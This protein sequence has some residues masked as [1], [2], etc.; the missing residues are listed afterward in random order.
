MAGDDPS[1]AVK[2]PAS[3][4]HNID[5]LLQKEAS[6]VNLVQ[7]EA[8]TIK[9]VT[10]SL[11]DLTELSVEELDERENEAVNTIKRTF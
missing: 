8:A 7:N 10:E 1:P 9:Q 6:S 2:P 3:G 4:S 5:N 11:S